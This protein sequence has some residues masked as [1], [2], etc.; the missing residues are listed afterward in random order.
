MRQCRGLFNPMGEFVRTQFSADYII[1]TLGFDLRQ[2][3]GETEDQSAYIIHLHSSS[4]KPEPMQTVL[5]AFER[6]VDIT[7]CGTV[8]AFVEESDP[9][10][11][12][13]ESLGWVCRRLFPVQIIW[14]DLASR[15]PG[16]TGTRDN[17]LEI[18]VSADARAAASLFIECFID[19]WEWYFERMGYRAGVSSKAN[20]D[21]IALRYIQGATAY[22]IASVGGA[23]VGI[24]SVIL[25]S[26]VTPAEFHTG[27][28]VVPVGG[29]KN[30][31]TRLIGCETTARNVPRLELRK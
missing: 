2:G 27:V 9:A 26:S 29:G 25:R 6:E 20:L 23:P 1:S 14:D 11:A 4:P 22:F 21:D 8:I 7:R 12:A 24:N 30:I 3:Q 18:K 19:Q 31:G 13:L 17:N 28:G 5:S 15:L 10:G 16:F